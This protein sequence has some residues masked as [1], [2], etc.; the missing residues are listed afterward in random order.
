ML[1]SPDSAS[2]LVTRAVCSALCNNIHTTYVPENWQR[3]ILRLLGYFPQQVALSA[4]NRFQ[5]LSGLDSRE[6]ND[7]SIEE[8]A[9]TRLQDYGNLD[10]K[11]ETITIGPALGGASAHIALAMRSLFLPI[12]FIFTLRG[13]SPSGHALQY[14]LRSSEMALKLAKRNPGVI[15]IQHFD[16]IHD[17]WL[18][19]YANHLRIKLIDL[20]ESYKQFIL[21]YLNPGGKICYLDSSAQWLRYQVG[22]RSYFQVGGWGDILPNEFLEG[23]QRVQLYQQ[24][25]GFADTDWRLPGFNPEPGAESEWGCEPIFTQALTEFCAQNDFD[26]V[27][28]RASEPH[29]YSRLAFRAVASQLEMDDRQPAGVLVEMFSQFDATAVIL[30]GLLPIWLV[31]NTW[32]SLKYL[33]SML[34]NIPADRPVFFSPLTTF[35][36]TPDLVPWEEWQLALQDFNWINIG[37][38]STH[39]PADTWALLDWQKPLWRWIEQNPAPIRSVLTPEFIQELNNQDNLIPDLSKD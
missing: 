23:S 20:P 8:I 17:G 32:D 34:D 13:G 1:E 28:I 22:E 25:A 9:K 29:E 16:P 7:L 11:F 35:T 31:F 37:T 26:L 24:Q 38:R 2:P 15:T 27:R 6:L 5:R 33:R 36:M 12:S 21:R 3:P 30:S 14:Y 4:I 19:R 10:G 39:Y 18:T